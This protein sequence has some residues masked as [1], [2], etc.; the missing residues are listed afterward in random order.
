MEEKKNFKEWLSKNAI[1]A[2]ICALILGLVLGA[3]IMY[4]CSGGTKIASVKGKAIT[5]KLLYNRMKKYLSIDVVLEEVDSAI[6]NK[7]YT[8]DKDEIA[9]VKKTAQG[10]IDMYASYYGYSQEEFLSGNGFDSF[11]DFVDYLSL[12]YKRTLY[13]YDTIEKQLEKDAVKKYYDE[14]AFGKVNT[15]HILVKTS[16]DKTDEEALAIANEIIGRLDNGEDF[17]KV[18]EEYK[19]K[20]KDTIVVEDLGEKGAFDH[21]ED[22]YVEGMKLLNKGEYSKTPVQTSYGYHVI[23]CVDKTEKTEKISRKDKM[24]IVEHLASDIISEDSNLY[25]KTLIQMRKDAKLKFLDKNLEEKYIEYCSKYSD[26][27]DKTDAETTVET[28][29]TENDNQDIDIE[30]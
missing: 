21:L 7:K 11:E 1:S 13:F 26:E 22:A 17:D 30:E 16:E 9:D 14:N 5:S 15:K 23:Y 29:D 28:T 6:L 2:L 27:E 20:Y 12:D 18:S 19:E 8:L 25:Y 24:E 4:F 3:G 10:Y